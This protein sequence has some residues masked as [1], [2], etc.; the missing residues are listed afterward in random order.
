MVIFG[1]IYAPSPR[2]KPVTI[3]CQV[4][5]LSFSGLSGSGLSVFRPLPYARRMATKPTANDVKR[6]R[7]RVLSRSTVLPA[8]GIGVITVILA[9]Q[10]HAPFPIAVVVGVV[11]TLAV[12]GMIALKRAFYGD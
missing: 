7:P 11:V 12:I 10:E 3:P 5:R 9:A 6:P 2:D 4:Q 1:M 8:T